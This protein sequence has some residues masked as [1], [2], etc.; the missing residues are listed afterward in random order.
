MRT[1]S[2]YYML[3]QRLIFV[4]LFYFPRMRTI[5]DWLSFA[6]YSDRAY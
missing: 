2:A 4:I 3:A 6:S 5:S 1:I